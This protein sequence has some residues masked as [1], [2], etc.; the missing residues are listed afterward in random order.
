MTLLDGPRTV[1]PGIEAVPVGG[2]TPGQLI[3]L[4][5]TASGRTVLASDAL[6]YY[7]ELDLDRPFAFVADLPAMYRGFDLLR[8]LAG[9][10]GHVLV[11]GHDPEVMRRFP[12]LEG[13]GGHAVRVG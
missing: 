9:R 8:D 2:H 1:A 11:P 3:V 13:T 7:E 12:V 6:H 4:V 5:T 10:P